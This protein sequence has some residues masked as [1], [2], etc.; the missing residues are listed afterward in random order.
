MP[1]CIVDLTAYYLGLTMQEQCGECCA[2]R[3]Q[4]PRA[5]ALLRQISRGEGDLALLQE[6]AK[7]AE[8]VLQGENCPAARVGA[9]I[10][11]DAL[12]NYDEEFAAHLRDRYCPAGVCDIRYVVEI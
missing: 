1:R 2:C 10:V 5:H 6:L 9:R 4:L 11:K 3:E 7:V 12:E 8:Q